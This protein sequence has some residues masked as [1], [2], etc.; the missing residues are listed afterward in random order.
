MAKS[1]DTSASEQLTL[2]GQPDDDGPLTD[3]PDAHPDADETSVAPAEVSPVIRDMAER[4]PRSVRLGTSTWSFPGWAGIVYDKERTPSDL[5]RRGLAAYAQHP[6]LRS[7]G[8][9]RTFYAP[10]GADEF[11]RYAADVPSDFRFLVKAHQACTFPKLKPRGAPRDAPPAP[12]PFYLDPAYAIE[13]VIGPAVAGLGGTLGVVLF[14][15]PP[16][17]R[18]ESGTPDDFADRLFLFLD[19]LPKKAPIAVEVRNAEL[20]APRYAAV[21]AELENLAHCYVVHPAAAP[22]HAQRDLVPL[23]DQPQL[24]CRW[25]LHAGQSYVGAKSRY[26]PFDRLVDPDPGARRA[27]A[28]LLVRAIAGD[29]DAIVVINNKAEGSAPLSAIALARELAD[30]LEHPDPGEGDD[31]GP[32][33]GVA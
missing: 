30:L 12:N 32:R 1:R 14:Q 31:D 11:A 9:D 22:L 8:V 23:R 7:V 33:D 3:A 13:E 5:A 24:V 29:L 10:I 19:A 17:A 21:I 28:E 20:L 27:Y 25:M 6:A 26:E 16:L 2:F 4:L 18:A 15:F